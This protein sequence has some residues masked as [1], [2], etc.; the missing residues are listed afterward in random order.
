MTEDEKAVA[1]LLY[2]HRRAGEEPASSWGRKYEDWSYQHPVLD[3]AANQALNFALSEIPFAR[4]AKGIPG[5]RNVG[6]ILESAGRM[7][8]W[9]GGAE[10]HIAEPKLKW[11]PVNEEM[12]GGKSVKILNRESGEPVGHMDFSISRPDKT[13]SIDWA[14]INNM[15][16]DVGTGHLLHIKDEL[17]QRYPDVQKVRFM[18]L[19]KE[20][21]PP[22]KP[23][24]EVTMPVKSGTGFKTTRVPVA[25]LP[26]D[27]EPP[28]A[29]ERS[30]L[31]E[32][33]KAPE[34]QT[35]SAKAIQSRQDDLIDRLL[36]GMQ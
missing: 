1:Q 17:L 18:R 24:F 15:P 19:P 25:D 13:M 3:F 4:I 30:M 32:F 16:E 34:A 26:E 35:T 27:Y 12:F 36:K 31:Q 22:D 9:G 8:D 14:E 11:G 20:G 2:Q 5:L 28:T 7:H 29:G 6:E 21:D 33:M 10:Q 23:M